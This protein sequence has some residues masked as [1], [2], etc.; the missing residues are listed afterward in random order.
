MNAQETNKR[1]SNSSN[2][3]LGADKSTDQPLLIYTQ[4]EVESTAVDTIFDELFKR[5]IIKN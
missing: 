1:E 4:E 5:L 2:R 3:F